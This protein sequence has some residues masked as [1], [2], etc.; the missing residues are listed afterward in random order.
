MK[1]FLF[2]LA[3]LLAVT[4]AFAQSD[5]KYL[6]VNSELT[7]EDPSV[8]NGLI[9]TLSAEFPAR[10]SAM[11]CIFFC[12]EGLHITFV[13]AG[14]D[15]PITFYNARG[16]STT[17]S[18]SIAFQETGTDPDNNGM[19]AFVIANMTAG[20]YQV[21]GS[22]VQYGAIK[23]EAGYYEE[24]ILA[25][26]E[27]DETY[28]G[29]NVVVETIPSSGQ[30]LRGGTI[31]ELGDKSHPFMTDAT[32]PLEDPQPVVTA[33][34]PP[35]ITFA[36]E[37]T[38]QMTVTVTADEGC[39]LIVNGEAVEGNPYT[40]TVDRADIYTAGTVEVT[41]KA[42]K[43]GQES[44]EATKSQAFVVADR[45]TAAEPVINF[46]ETMN[47]NDE[48]TKVEVVVTNATS[49]VI[50]VDGELTDAQVF[51]ANYTADQVITVEAVNDPGYPYVANDNSDSY[52]LNKLA[53]ITPAAP[54]IETS[55]D[56][57]YVYV[58]ITWNESDGQQIYT[59]EYQYERPAYGEEAESYDVE[60]YTEATDK[61][62]ES[63]RATETINV[64]A[65][66]PVWQSVAAP[67]INYTMDDNYVY[68]TI[69]W[70]TTT[71]NQVY[72]GEYQY[73][74]PAYGEEAK[75]YDVEAYTEADYPYSESAHA[76]KTIPVPA[77]DPVWQN[78]AAP[79]INYTMD[80]DYVYV[81]V[82]WPE[83]TGNHVYTGAE[84]YERPAYGEE[85]KSYDVEAYTEANYPYSE[86]AHATETIPVPAK[87]PVWQNV[88]KPVIETSM[89]DNYVYVTITWPENAGPHNYNGQMS[90]ERTDADYSVS[91]EAYTAEQ[92]P[93]RESEHATLDI[94]VPAKEPVVMKNYV[95]VTS[96]DQLEAGKKY[97]FVAENENIAMGPIVNGF[98]STVTVTPVTRGADEV[99]AP[100]NIELTLGGSAGAWTLQFA[101]GMYLTAG[102]STGLNEG[103]N[104]T[105]WV[106]TDNNGALNGLR[107]KHADYNRAIRKH[108]SMDRFGNYSTSDNNSEW[109]FIY[110]EK[111]DAPVLEPTA[112][113]VITSETGKY[114]DEYVTITCEDEDAV[115]YYRYEY[116]GQWTAW[117]E[118]DGPIHLIENGTYN[119]E[120]YAQATDK[121]VSTTAEKEVVVSNCTAVNELN[122]DKAVA[123]VRYFNMAGQ[124]MQE[125]NGMTI[126]VTTY[127]DGT[128][129]AVKVMK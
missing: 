96:T 19:G 126:I 76:T 110:V 101:N 21:D 11:H 81:T 5:A 75:S 28:H 111:E 69:T 53:K 114:N 60:A 93:Y 122:G 1:K 41:A 61:Y 8:E 37:E 23:W 14:A 78:V 105:N 115:I 59:G 27:Y 104:A 13:E 73:E 12:P 106:I 123:S 94:E 124:E 121:E 18:P 117:A 44:T 15:Y 29:G 84:K 46:V 88:A 16:R 120:A 52:T 66:D 39:T 2:T 71:G 107:A 50:R 58:T 86:S 62:N 63:P 57:N 10:V 112:E 40:Y 35:V 74:R 9:L 42:V 91:V 82:T 89:D 48:V 103:E 116:D 17:E 99:Q 54:V 20:F 79:E 128:T 36:G 56:D 98:G 70:P 3:A 4:T 33:P 85:A 113:P 83:T 129:S 25:Y 109:A 7:T 32:E 64:P 118:Y 80:A 31:D 38:A 47:E 6:Y 24:F 119:F 55:M 95:K 90:Y 97:I 127:T 100:A 49:Y 125:A 43:D 87:D 26:A 92:Y 34:N 77:K 65:K 102:N 67:E 45:P 108:N 22:W 68:V 30:D 51:E 72:T